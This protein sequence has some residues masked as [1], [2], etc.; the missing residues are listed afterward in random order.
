MQQAY[1]YVPPQNP[2]ATDHTHHRGVVPLS[3]PVA[4][5]LR[6]RPRAGHPSVAAAVV[7]AVV[8]VVFSLPHRRCRCY[9]RRLHHGQMIGAGPGLGRRQRVDVVDPAAAT[10][11]QVQYI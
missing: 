10:P 3:P 8:V 11:L 1:E 6:P 7:A 5:P 4:A 2:G 9:R